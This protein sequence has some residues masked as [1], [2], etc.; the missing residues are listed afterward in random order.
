MLE[1]VKA[2]KMTI[3]GQFSHHSGG[4]GPHSLMLIKSRVCLKI[5]G[6]RLVPCI[7][8][9]LVIRILNLQ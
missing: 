6:H 7:A 2:C 9:P 8:G 4:R 5:V 1:I 3:D